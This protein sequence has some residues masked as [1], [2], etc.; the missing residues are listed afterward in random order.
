MQSQKKEKDG[1]LSYSPSPN[2]T[3]NQIGLVKLQ[4]KQT[5]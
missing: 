1:I 5:S 2:Y 4:R 3:L